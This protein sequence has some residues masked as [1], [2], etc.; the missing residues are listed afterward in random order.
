LLLDVRRHRP[1]VKGRTTNFDNPQEAR[2]IGSSAAIAHK[3][4]FFPSTPPKRSAN[5]PRM[6]DISTVAD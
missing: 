5:S 4:G 1:I 6:V 3:K 2:K